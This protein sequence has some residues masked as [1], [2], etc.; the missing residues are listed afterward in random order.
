[1]SSGL[2]CPDVGTLI[3][4]VSPFYITYIPRT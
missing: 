3:G 4:L 1:V 2:F